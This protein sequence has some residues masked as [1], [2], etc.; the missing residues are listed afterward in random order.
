VI[1]STNL[2]AYDDPRAVT[3][4]WLRL[5]GIIALSMAGLAVYFYLRRDTPR[6]AIE[7]VPMACAVVAILGQL[8]F[9]QK[10]DVETTA[11]RTL[12]WVG[13]FRR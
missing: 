1:V 2:T 11:Q 4:N 12:F 8:A 13:L 5:A 3:L 6:L 7:W 10:Y 9:V